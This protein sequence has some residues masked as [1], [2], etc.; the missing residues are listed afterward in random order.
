M[1]RIATLLFVVTLTY[2][3]PCMAAAIS[4]GDAVAI[5]LREAGCRKSKDCDVRGGLKDGK[6]VFVVWFV[7]GRNPDG[8]PQFAPGGWVGLTLNGKGDVID[9]MAGA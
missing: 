3:L 9:R 4:K 6:W 1:A 7:M 5:A 2:A 8:S